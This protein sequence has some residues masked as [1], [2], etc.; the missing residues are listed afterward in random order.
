MALEPTEARRFFEE[1]VAKCQEAVAETR[2]K[3]DRIV[4]DGVGVDARR[5]A[6]SLRISASLFERQI[7]QMCEWAKAEDAK[8]VAS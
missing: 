8:A 4:A 6:K 2:Q 3:A 7:R 1:T 5:E